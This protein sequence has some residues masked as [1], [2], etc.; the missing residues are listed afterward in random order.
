MA[1]DIFDRVKISV[2]QDST[3]YNFLNLGENT[4]ISGIGSGLI[5]NFPLG[6]VTSTATTVS[7]TRI[8]GQNDT[9]QP[10]P[11]ATTTNPTYSF[12][13]RQAFGKRNSK[14]RTNKAIDVFSQYKFLD[15]S[16]YSKSFYAFGNRCFDMVGY[17]NHISVLKK[18]TKPDLKEKLHCYR[19]S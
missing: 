18:S 7:F 5:Y 2:L 17:G 6:T 3:M 15:L 9:F 14:I 13:Y 4:V 8:C 10:V 1:R 16:I 11:I 12:E 19:F